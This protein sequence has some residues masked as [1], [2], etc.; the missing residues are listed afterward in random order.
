VPI[1]ER[2][3]RTIKERVRAYLQS[4]PYTLMLSL[5]RYLVEFCVTT[6]NLLP[7]EH[8]EDPTSPYELFTGLKVDFARQLRIS[9]G[10]YAECRNPNRKLVNGP[11]PRSD[12]CITLLP[13]P[14]QQGSYL[15]F[16]LGSRR[17][18]IRTKWVELPFPDDIIARC[19][20]LA[21]KQGKKLR[22]LP[23]FSRGEP[24][25]EDDNSIAE[26]SDHELFGHDDAPSSSDSDEDASV[27][28]DETNTDDPNGDHINLSDNHLGGDDDSSA[29]PIHYAEADRE[30][31]L[32]MQ[33]PTG[34]YETVEP[35][36]LYVEQPIATEPVHQYSTRSKGEATTHEPYKEG[37]RWVNIVQRK[38]K[39]KKA[40]W[41]AMLTL[42]QKNKFGVYS[43]MTIGEAI[44]RYEAGRDKR[45]TAINKVKCIQVP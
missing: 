6:I 14:N 10:D 13:M 45:A 30:R 7:D 42:K 12:P 25:D 27:S 24:R 43:N 9:F 40:M 38:R 32:D 15:F 16:D 28:S 39:F 2:K 3:I 41:H 1:V 4:I 11:K 36:N 35:D 22:V 37:K 5:L 17:T 21:S 18:V 31:M 19:N 33:N 8:R 23:F 34:P 20:H 44:D 26:M 29:D